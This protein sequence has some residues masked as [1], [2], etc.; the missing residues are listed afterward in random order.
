MERATSSR[1]RPT[2]PRGAHAVEQL[3]TLALLH[4]RRDPR[5]SAGEAERTLTDLSLE[6]SRTITAKADEISTAVTQ[7]TKEMAAVLSD[8][9]GGVLSAITEKGEK[10]AADITKATERG[11][12]V[13]RAE[14]LR[15]HPYDA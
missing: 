5:L 11:H 7:R 3:G 15:L 1:S 13:D 4:R 10:F 14:G 9:H 2:P 8:K 6:V 12:A